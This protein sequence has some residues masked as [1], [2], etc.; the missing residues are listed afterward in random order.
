MKNNQWA[1][2]VIDG[3][4]AYAKHTGQPDLQVAL[5]YAQAIAAHDLGHDRQTPEPAEPRGSRVNI[6]R[7]PRQ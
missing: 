1:V 3:L 7:F 4:V 2:E 5:L 6:I